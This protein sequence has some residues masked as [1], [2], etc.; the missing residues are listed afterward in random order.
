MKKWIAA[1][2]ALV[3]L[4]VGAALYIDKQHTYRMIERSIEIPSP[5]GKL[6]GTLVLPKSFTEK[7]GLVLFVHGDGP[8]NATHDDGYKPLWERLAAKGYAS[9]SLNKRGINGSEGNWLDQSIDDRVLEAKQAIAWAKEQPEIDRSRIG[10][11]GASQAGWV[12]PKLAGEEPLAFSI[13]VSPAI[14]WLRQGEYNTR[15]QMAKD[16][17]SQV[18]IEKQVAQEKEIL[19]LLEANASYEDY[20]RLV[21]GE[22]S[23]TSERW[24]FV[25]RNYKADATSDL[26]NFNSPVLLLLGD[27]DIHVDFRETEA[28]YEQAIPSSLLTVNVF[29]DTEHSMLRT[30]TADSDLRATFISLFAPRSITTEAYMDTI[31]NFLDHLDKEG[32]HN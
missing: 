30:A 12:L 8:I 18:E 11:W 5:H 1:A 16:G 3:I 31:D 10:V 19:P 24:D 17:K 6:T 32:H 29:P 26:A 20:R 25:K 13:L 4:T 23:M 28:V 22:H 7:I 9:L 14:Q 21:Q 27:Q 15:R 2:L